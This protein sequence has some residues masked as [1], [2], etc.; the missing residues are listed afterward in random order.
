VDFIYAASGPQAIHE[1]NGTVIVY[2]S[3]LAS[4]EQRQ[5]I[6]DIAYGRAGGGCAFTAFAPTFRYVLDPQ[7]VPIEMKVE[8]KRSRFVVP[9]ILEVSLALHIDPVLGSERDVRLHL[10]RGFIWT[11]AQAAKTAVMKILSPNLNFNHSG[12]NSFYTV[13]E[14]QGP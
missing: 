5:A 8:S 2:I 1:G 11:T 12:R 13:V 10:P 7:F 9:G 14:Y 6:C 4:P 3:E